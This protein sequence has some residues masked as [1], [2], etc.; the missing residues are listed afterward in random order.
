MAL[1][2]AST[3]TVSYLFFILFKKL[4]VNL[5]AIYIN[6]VCLQA[7]IIP[8]C[9]AF[10]QPSYCLKLVT[11]TVGLCLALWVCD[12]YKMVK[13]FLTVLVQSV[14]TLNWHLTMKNFVS[15]FFGSSLF[16]LPL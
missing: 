15:F 2:V 9:C 5:K 4:N 8:C 11:E 10:K 6:T 7:N 1:T 16:E 3:H 14:F 13:N 12:L